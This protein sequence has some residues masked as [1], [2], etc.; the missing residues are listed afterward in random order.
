[1]NKISQK[2]GVGNV[3]NDMGNLDR[4][5]I[6]LVFV[7][8]FFKKRSE[9]NPGVES[10]INFRCKFFFCILVLGNSVNIE[11]TSFEV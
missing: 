7:R 2:R 1:M 3:E 5:R 4:L 11:P 6:V 8:L 9:L 10:E